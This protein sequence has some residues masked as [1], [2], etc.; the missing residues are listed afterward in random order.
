MSACSEPLCVVRVFTTVEL[1][2]GFEL[3]LR[4]ADIE[5]EPSDRLRET[6]SVLRRAGKRAQV[7]R[8]CSRERSRSL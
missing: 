4:D 8:R 1:L 3:A 2:T 5:A 6:A 7:T